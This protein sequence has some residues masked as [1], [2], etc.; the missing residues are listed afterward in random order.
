MTVPRQERANARRPR[1]R[2]GPGIGVALF[3]V[4]LAIGALLVWLSQRNAE[5]EPAESA[6]GEPIAA[7]ATAPADAQPEPAVPPP[8]PAEESIEVPSLA[9]SDPFVREQ[10]GPLSPLPAL[11]TWLAQAGLAQRFAASVDNIAEGA[12]PRAHLDFLRPSESFRVVGSDT[13][14]RIDPASYARYDV[15]ADVVESLDAAACASA[16]RWLAVLFQQAYEE[17]GYPGRRFHER[18]VEAIDVLL[19]APVLEES[20]PLVRHIGRYQWADEE[21]QRASDAV[22]QLLR[23]GPRNVVRVQAKLR[24]LRAAIAPLAGALDEGPPAA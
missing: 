9:E 16:Y 2:R 15:I 12:S 21:I 14:P 4:A 1:R 13:N 17:L 6:P 3:A 20:P 8:P 23:M 10:I 22:K 5:P 7:A 11:A 24:E 19:A 18:A